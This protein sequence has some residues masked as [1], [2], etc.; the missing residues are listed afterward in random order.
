MHE[1]HAD[2]R[3]REGQL[4]CL[5]ALK[6]EAS[7]QVVDKLYQTKSTRRKKQPKYMMISNKG[8]SFK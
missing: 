8:I 3:S 1:T 6:G 2:A 5:T 7:V 4:H